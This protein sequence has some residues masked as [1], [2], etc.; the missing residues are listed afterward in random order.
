MLLLLGLSKGANL[1]DALVKAMDAIERDFK[2]LLGQLPKDYTKFE[3][4]L[5]EDLL[6]T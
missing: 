5:L 3:N 2:P 1:G 6:R 4:S